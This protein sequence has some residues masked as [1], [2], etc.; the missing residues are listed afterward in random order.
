MLRSSVD[1]PHPLGPEQ[2]GHQAGLDVEIE[3]VE[4]P[5]A[6]TDDGQPAHLHARSRVVHQAVH[7][8]AIGPGRDARPPAVRRSLSRTRGS[9]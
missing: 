7:E 9:K 4:D 8:A 5:V 3:P 2:P 1:F 6:A